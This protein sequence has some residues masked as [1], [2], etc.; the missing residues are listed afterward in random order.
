MP[1]ICPILTLA[2]YFLVNGFDRKGLSVFPGAGQYERYS[3]ALK[4]LFNEPDVIAE[5]AEY[6]LTPADLGAHSSRKGSSTF[7][8]SGSPDGPRFAAIMTRAGWQMP[9]VTGKYISLNDASDTF[10]GRTVCGLPL[11][12]PEFAV[13][14]PFFASK[15]DDIGVGV[16][17]AFPDAPANVAPKLL[18]FL[19]ASLVWHSDTLRGKLP[20]NHP[21]LQTSLFAQPQLLNRLKRLVEC[22]VPH[23]NDVLKA[24]GVPASVMIMRDF[25]ELNSTIRDALVPAVNNLVPSIAPV[26]KEVLM[27][28][29]YASGQVNRAYVDEKL[30]SVIE[31]QL[32][33]IIARSGITEAAEMLRGLAGNTLTIPG[34]APAP[35][36]DVEPWWIKHKRTSVPDSFTEFPK[37]TVYTMWMQYCCGDEASGCPPFCD[38]DGRQLP[39]PLKPHQKP[40]DQA[41]EKKMRQLN[42]RNLVKRLSDLKA[43]MGLI[44]KRVDQRMAVVRPGPQQAVAFYEAG[45]AAIFELIPETT[46]QMQERRVGQMMWQTALDIIRTQR[47]VQQQRHV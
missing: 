30:K 27:E 16:S 17:M 5:L 12:R 19:L 25:N 3:K 44:E 32:T 24:T 14:P 1:D 15:T 31:S 43:L 28:R 42:H 13:L 6:G 11:Q 40:I 8:A 46:V 22:R 35:A 45:S 21:L 47:A 23:M 37:G 10:V 4:R 9:G 26:L 39:S 20:A 33:D 29:E 2:E 34:P 18:E 7:A 36:A 41:E 38:V